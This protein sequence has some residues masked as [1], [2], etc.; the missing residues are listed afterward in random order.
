MSTHLPPPTPFNSPSKDVSICSRVSQVGDIR[1]AGVT[2]AILLVYA[3]SAIELPALDWGR[4]R[5]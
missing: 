2:G 5:S 4:E 1:H 3:I